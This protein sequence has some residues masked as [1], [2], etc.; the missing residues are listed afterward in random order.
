MQWLRLRRAQTGIGIEND[1]KN[2]P[3]HPD[4]LFLNFGT[5][6][7]KRSLFNLFELNWSDTSNTATVFP[8]AIPTCS[9]PHRPIHIPVNPWL[10]CED[11]AYPA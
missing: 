1:A 10:L 5:L 4:H 2:N 7:R 9:Y 3:H 8:R 11:V 6:V